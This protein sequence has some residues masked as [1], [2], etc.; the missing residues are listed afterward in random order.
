MINTLSGS[1]R[2]FRLVGIDVFLHWSWFVVAVF[3]INNRRDSYSSLA[4]NAAEYVALLRERRTNNMVTTVASVSENGLGSGTAV[5]RI[6]S[7]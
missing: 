6:L 4:W 2:L 5:S 7:T 3:E 1:F